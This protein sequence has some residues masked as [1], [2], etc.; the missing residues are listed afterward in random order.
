MVIKNS[1]LSKN[2]FENKNFWLI[3]ILNTVDVIDRERSQVYY[4]SDFLKFKTKMYLKDT[5]YMNGEHT[6]K[7]L[8]S[9][10]KIISLKNYCKSIFQ[11][12]KS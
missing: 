4:S 2:S 9:F 5:S 6:G 1:D 11:G 7:P 10:K 8:L 3:K 12:S